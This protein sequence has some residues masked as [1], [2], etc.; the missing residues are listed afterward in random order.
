MTK[1]L[2]AMFRHR[3]YRHTNLTSWLRSRGWKYLGGGHWEHPR[4]GRLESPYAVYEQAAYEH[5]RWSKITHCSYLM[6]ITIL[7]GIVI[8]LTIL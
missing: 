5:Y 3:F 7:L 4:H 6:I 8:G 2:A 1:L